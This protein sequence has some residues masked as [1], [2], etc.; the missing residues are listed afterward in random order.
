MQVAPLPENE[1]Q[2]LQTLRLFDVL[3]SEPERAFDDITAVSTSIFETPICLITLVDEN[4]QWFKS[5]HGLDIDETERDVAFCSHA[6]HSDETFVVEDA[7]FDFRFSDNPLVED[8]PRIRFYAGAPL[9]VAEDIRIGTLCV[10]DTTPRSIDPERLHVLEVLRDAVVANLELR[11]LAKQAESRRE[12]ISLC[13]WCRR[14]RDD[15]D[16][17]WLHADEYLKQHN[18]L[19]H[20]ICET[21]S[22][23]MMRKD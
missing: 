4:R 1:A 9:T 11:R 13:A 5:A 17:S 12:L 15:G 3:D 6:I 7:R 10:I 21:C 18:E 23:K 2:R 22:E 19:T 20:S 16:E 8:E 14:V